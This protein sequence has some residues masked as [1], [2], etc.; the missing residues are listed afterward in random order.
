VTAAP[1][2]PEQF[3]TF[4]REHAWKRARD[5]PGADPHWYLLRERC[6]DELAFAA[7]AA[8]VRQH[9]YRH[10]YRR[11]YYQ[12]VDCIVDDVTWRLWVMP[13]DPPGNEQIINKAVKELLGLDRTRAK[14][15]E[16]FAL[17]ADLVMA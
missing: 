10:R 4:V 3:E 2:T 7:A 15:D 16:F 12:C 1:L 11:T 8:Y 6:R 5:Y 17:R 9:G 14:I 13:G